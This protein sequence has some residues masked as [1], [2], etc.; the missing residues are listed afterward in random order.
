MSVRRRFW[1]VAEE[2]AQPRDAERRYRNDNDDHQD[3][4]L[5]KRLVKKTGSGPDNSFPGVARFQYLSNDIAQMDALLGQMS[6]MIATMTTMK[7]MMLTMHSS[8]SSLYDQMEVMSQNSTA[9][10]RC[11]ANTSAPR[12]RFPSPR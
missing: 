9:M 11:A 5:L 1:E 2:G 12:G 10:G 7:T 3:S 4:N 8:M 6:P